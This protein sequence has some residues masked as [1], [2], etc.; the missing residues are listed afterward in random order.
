MKISASSGKENYKTTLESGS[1]TLFADEKPEKG[2]KG[3]GFTPHELLA[4]SLASCTSIT[5]KMYAERK[6]WELTDVSVT[7]KINNDAVVGGTLMECEIGL[8]GNLTDEQRR[9]L[10]EIANHCPIHKILSNPI[11]I[12]TKFR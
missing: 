1:Y 12:N 10:L 6:K 3:E 11:E 5:M 9:R 7:V 8:Q 4:A 2:G